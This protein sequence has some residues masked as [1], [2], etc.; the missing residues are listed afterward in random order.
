MTDNALARFRQQLLAELKKD[1]PPRWFYISMAGPGGFWG[2]AFIK[3]RGPT[4]AWRLLH[5]TGL[6]PA[7]RLDLKLET[8]TFE[9]PEEKQDLVTPDRAWRVLRKADLDA[10]DEMYLGEPPD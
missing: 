9:V 2:S 8:L 5:N 10:M 6:Y 7:D 1:D 3:A 4:E